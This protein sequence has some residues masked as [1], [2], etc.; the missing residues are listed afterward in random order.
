MTMMPTNPRA[1]ADEQPAQLSKFD[2]RARQVLDR[3]KFDELKAQAAK[4]LLEAGQ[5][6][7]I[8]DHCIAQVRAAAGLCGLDL[9]RIPVIPEPHDARSVADDLRAVALHSDALVEAIGDHLAENFNGVDRK[10]FKD[11]LSNAIDGEAL[12]D[13]EAAA[14]RLEEEYAEEKS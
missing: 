8:P 1:V 3:A 4:L 12:F 13:C 2:T 5:L 14:Q 6:Y 7:H 9:H 10:L 11:V